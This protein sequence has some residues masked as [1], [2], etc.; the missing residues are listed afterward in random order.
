MSSTHTSEGNGNG[1][2]H[3]HVLSAAGVFIALG[4]IYG[5]IGT[6]VLYV[7]KAI[8]GEDT[9]SKELVYGGMSCVFWTLTLVTSFKYVYLALNADNR[10]EGGIFALYALVRRHKTKWVIFPAIIGAAS[11]IADGFITPP[12]SI[13]S[14]VEGLEFI[15]DLHKFGIKSYILPL[16]YG[17]LIALFVIQ[18]FGTNVIGRAFGPVMFIWFSTMS[19]LGLVYIVPNP[20]ILLALSPHYAVDLL[21]HYPKGFVLLGAVF[22]CTTGAEALYSDLG[23]CGKENIRVSWIFVKIALII[24]YLG[25]SA[26]LMQFEGDTLAQAGGGT[27]LPPFYGMMSE[28]FRPF[29]VVIAT[30]AAI[31]ASQALITGTFTLANEAMKLKLFPNMKVHYPAHLKGQIYIA[32]MNWILLGG[33][34]L[35]VSVF[36]ESS[37]MEAAYGLAITINLLMTTSLL[38]WHL[39]LKHKKDDSFFKN[40]KTVVIILFI[41]IVIESAFFL[42]GLA[43]FFHGGW[44]TCLIA[45]ILFGIM[46]IMYQARLLREK[47]TDYVAIDGEIK[48]T[49]SDLSRD[50]TVPR[51]ATNLVYLCMSGD[52]SKID[53]NIIY[54]ITKKRPKRADTYWFL[55]VDIADDPSLKQYTVDEIIPKKCY[56]IRLSFGFKVPHKVNLMF[57]HVVD[58]LI[59]KGKI[60]ALSHYPGLKKHNIK[61]DFKFILLNTRV[62]VDEELSPFNQFVIRSYRL[63]K[64]F[65]LSPEEHFNLESTNIE[66]ERIPINIGKRANMKLEGRFNFVTPVVVEQNGKLHITGR[67][68][69]DEEGIEG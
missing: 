64:R 38:T 68:D 2:G 63:I 50:Y 46:Y 13:A 59:A 35:V 49:I 58:E 4:I 55:H 6:S 8:I 67:V 44:F 19:L 42:S 33:C 48:D 18:Q 32:A 45:L 25:Q 41:F 10:G 22:L 1:N 20:G 62:S 29:G 15:P 40:P 37:R 7:F 26:Y 23:H 31:I 60:D 30:L 65:S 69:D 28:S 53:Q 27:A 12:I 43:K 56:F 52:P 21:L 24:N 11:L 51:E 14:A 57:R 9:I 47:Y 34:M 3:K 17:I 36:Q 66:V 39:Y 16:I 54:S 61:Q 5:D